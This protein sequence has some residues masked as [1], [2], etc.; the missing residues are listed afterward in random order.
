MGAKKTAASWH[1]VFLASNRLNH[2][3]SRLRHH[4]GPEV[5]AVAPDGVDDRAVQAVQAAQHRQLLR[6]AL[7]LRV[8]RH[9]QPEQRLAG[10]ETVPFAAPLLRNVWC[11]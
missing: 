11:W 8:R 9:R 6:G 10:R 7:Q 3:V 4:I 2:C 5:V 1:P